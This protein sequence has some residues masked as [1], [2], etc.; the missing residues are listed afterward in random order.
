MTLKFISRL[1]LSSELQFV[2]VT[3]LFNLHLNVLTRI[4]SLTSL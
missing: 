1:E 3:L 4:A 2:H